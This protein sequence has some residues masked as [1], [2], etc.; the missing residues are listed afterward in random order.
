MNSGEYMEPHEIYRDSV[1]FESV[2]LCPPLSPEIG[3]QVVKSLSGVCL[4][5]V[6]LQGGISLVYRVAQGFVLCICK[7]YQLFLIFVNAC[8]TFYDLR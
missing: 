3:G 6:E 8:R 2:P 1:N 7:G 4:N 5:A